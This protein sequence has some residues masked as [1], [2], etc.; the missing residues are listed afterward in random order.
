MLKKL[1]EFIKNNHEE[2]N[3]D[4]Y[5][6]AKYIQLNDS[7]LKQIADAIDSGELIE[8]PAS[9]CNAD[10]FIFHFGT[11]IILVQKDNSDSN[12][13][14]SAELSWETDFLSIRSTR[15]KTKGFYFINFEFDDNY[16]ATLKDTE[17]T[18]KDQIIN[19]DKNEEIVNKVMPVLKG[20][21]NAI[22]D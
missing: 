22:S 18:I 11:T 15:D 6:D 20:F 10:N 12:I 14:Y 5:L 9:S 7:Q 1:V 16:N 8:K 4:E 21:M 2:S 3:I 13:V 17:K 19:K